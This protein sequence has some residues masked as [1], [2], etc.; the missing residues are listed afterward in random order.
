MDSETFDFSLINL[1]PTSPVGNVVSPFF[2]SALYF[3]LL[4]NGRSFLIVIWLSSLV[5]IYLVVLPE[6]ISNNRGP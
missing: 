1:D 5:S 2:G 3:N 6:W 4:K